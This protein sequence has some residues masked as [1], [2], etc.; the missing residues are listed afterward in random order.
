ML[1]AAIKKN[2]FTAAERLYPVEMPYAT[3][4]IY[5]MSMEIPKGYV[6]D[7]LPKSTRLNFNED[8]GM[9]EY[10]ISADKEYIQLRCGLVFRKATYANGD[11]Q[12]LRDFYSFIV[13]KEAEQIVFKKIK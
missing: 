1:G 6:V 9:F 13:K 7:E 12:S 11:Y 3:D 5:T 4:D 8:E 10:L 2:P